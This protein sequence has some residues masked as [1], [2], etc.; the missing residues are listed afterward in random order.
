M[1]QN[2][3]DY[4]FEEKKV[5]LRCGRENYIRSSIHKPLLN[6]H[7]FHMIR[8][9]RHIKKV[10]ITEKLGISISTLDRIRKNGLDF[11]E[12]IKISRRAIRFSEEKVKEWI[13]KK[14]SEVED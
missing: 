4:K 6:Q 5:A 10:D 7:Q 9:P 14:Y 3:G 12:P 13:E 2:S 11:P 1:G 8:I